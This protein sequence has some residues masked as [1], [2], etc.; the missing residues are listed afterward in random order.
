[1][2]AALLTA[3]AVYF[4]FGATIYCGVMWALRFFF[5]PSW[6]GMTL[7]NVHDHFVV[8]TTA[9]TRFFLVVV[10]LMFAS[11]IVLL[12]TEWGEGAT[13]WATVIAFLGISV[14]TY[15]GWIH[16]IPVNRKIRD[17]APDNATLAVL[18]KKWMFLNSIRWITVTIMW[19]AAVWYFVAEGNF[20]KAVG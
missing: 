9:A 2:T 20:Y 1:M 10:P 4:L 7:D 6:T 14:S 3:N 19:G 5:Y 18:L 8:P 11:S 12:V 17:G 16:I 13:F 15:V